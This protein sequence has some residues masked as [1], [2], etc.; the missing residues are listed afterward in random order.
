MKIFFFRIIDTQPQSLM[1]YRI[2]A[3]RGLT[4][5]RKLRPQLSLKLQEVYDTINQHPLAPNLGPIPE[6]SP[7]THAV[8][9]FHA[10]TCAVLENIGSFYV[11]VWRHGNLKPTVKVRYKELLQCFWYKLPFFLRLSS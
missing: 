11:N 8:V 9:E 4:G 6:I 5:G 2:G 1:H 7:E 10:A 3:V